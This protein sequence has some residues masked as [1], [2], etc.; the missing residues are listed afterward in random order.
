MVPAMLVHQKI[1]GEG[2]IA[3]ESWGIRTENNFSN[4][5]EMANLKLDKEINIVAHVK[6]Q[7]ISQHTEVP[8]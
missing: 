5:S 7:S 4:Q 8:S 1:M 3:T 2:I 6:E